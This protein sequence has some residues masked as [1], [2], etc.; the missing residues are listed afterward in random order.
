MSVGAQDMN[1]SGY[2]VSDLD[3]VEFYWENNE[4]EVDA[5]FRPGIDTPFSPAVFDDLEI[6]GTAEKYIM[7]DEE[8][9]K[10]NSPPI[11]PVPERPKRTP[12][13]LTNCLFGTRIENNAD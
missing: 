6:R 5:V 4:L 12:A 13:M 10:E 3:D 2:Q 11:T 8:G 1:T 9:D 7:L